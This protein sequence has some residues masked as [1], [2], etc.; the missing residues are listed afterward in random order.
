MSWKD[1]VIDLAGDLSKEGLALLIKELDK[2]EADA[3]EPWKK[4][5]LAMVSDLLDIHGIEGLEI[6]K[7]IISQIGEGEVPNLEGLRIRTASDVLAKLQ[8]AEVQDRALH[9]TYI[10]YLTEVLAGLIKGLLLASPP[11]E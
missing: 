11:V 5:M 9:N 4:V 3:T 1:I 7:R 10:I 8:Q 6:A 2:L